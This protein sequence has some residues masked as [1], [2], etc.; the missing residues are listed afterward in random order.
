MTTDKSCIQHL[1]H[2]KHFHKDNIIGIAYRI[3]I[4]QLVVD[5][6]EKKL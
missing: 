4:I 2:C 5:F 1:K 6:N 3:E